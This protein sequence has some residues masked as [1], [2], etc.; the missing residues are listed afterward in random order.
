MR[1]SFCLY[2]KGSS[3]IW[4]F[5]NEGSSPVYP[6]W[7][8]LT[9]TLYD[10]LRFSLNLWKEEW[11]VSFR[12]SILFKM[13]TSSIWS[14]SRQWNFRK[15]VFANTQSCLEGSLVES[16]GALRKLY[17]SFIL[18]STDHA[19][20]LQD[21]DTLFTIIYL[22]QYIE[23]IFRRCLSRIWFILL[24]FFGSSPLTTGRTVM[25]KKHRLEKRRN[26]RDV[27]TVQY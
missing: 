26:R 13:T 6:V 25:A 4:T 24:L 17:A 7:P 21:K 5:P 19:V 23:N 16:S 14:F 12:C 20:P 3:I 1:T 8:D 2:S 18:W 11:K 9:T 15:M 27:R 22:S 10:E